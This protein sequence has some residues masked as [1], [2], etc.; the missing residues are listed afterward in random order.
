MATTAFLPPSVA[1]EAKQRAERKAVLTAALSDSVKGLLVD[2]GGKEAHASMGK[3]AHP[4]IVY[5]RESIPHRTT[6]RVFLGSDPDQLRSTAREA[7]KSTVGKTGPKT[8]K[9]GGNTMTQSQ[10]AIDMPDNPEPPRPKT[11]TAR[12]DFKPPPPS[13]GERIPLDRGAF[14]RTSQQLYYSMN[15]EGAPPFAP[16]LASTPAPSHAFVTVAAHP[17][18]HDNVCRLLRPAGAWEPGEETEAYNSMSRTTY[19]AVSGAAAAVR[20]PPPADEINRNAWIPG[21]LAAGLTA[22]VQKIKRLSAAK[23]QGEDLKKGVPGGGAKR[24]ARMEFSKLGRQSQFQLG[25]GA[26]GELHLDGTQAQEIGRYAHNG[27]M[28][29]TFPR[30]HAAGAELKFRE[31]DAA[32]MLREQAG[33]IA[34]ESTAHEAARQSGSGGARVFTKRSRKRVTDSSLPHFS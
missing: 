3:L 12:E 22:D 23:A 34:Y 2:V 9:K 17:H 21:S 27:A 14:N 26:A 32:G 8:M 16:A 28:N 5:Q 29:K 25:N 11:T 31:T 6:S 24:T 7:Y 33:P 13:A 18:I 1:D 20:V 30:G 15:P 19:G 4:N 10:I